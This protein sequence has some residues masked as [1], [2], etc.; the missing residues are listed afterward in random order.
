MLKALDTAQGKKSTAAN[1]IS[2]LKAGGRLGKGIGAAAE[3]FMSPAD[4]VFKV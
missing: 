1:L 3:V 4:L 2:K